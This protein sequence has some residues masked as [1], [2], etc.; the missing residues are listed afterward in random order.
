MLINT[1]CK[2]K[3]FTQGVAQACGRL[4]YACGVSKSGIH[5]SVNNLSVLMGRPFFPMY[6]W[7]AMRVLISVVEN[8]IQY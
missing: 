6:N 4:P 7:E 2:S 5:L 8:L 3:E 1:D